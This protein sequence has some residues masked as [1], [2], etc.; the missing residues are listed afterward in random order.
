[1][2]TSQFLLSNWQGLGLVWA[3]SNSFVYTT[4][5]V[6]AFPQ[7]HR[8]NLNYSSKSFLLLAFCF[9]FV[10]MV[11]QTQMCSSSISLSRLLQGIICIIERLKGETLEPWITGGRKLEEG[12]DLTFLLST[13]WAR[14]VL[15]TILRNYAILTYFKGIEK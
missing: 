1:M 10:C 7:S 9:V 3:I 2:N 8:L 12:P 6:W 4:L 11:D 15:K 13:I 5:L 14:T